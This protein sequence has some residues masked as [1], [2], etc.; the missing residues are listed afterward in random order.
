MDRST[1]LCKFIRKLRIDHDDRQ[2][3]M[4]VK[5]G[6]TPAFLSKVETQKRPMPQEWYY[7]LSR[8]YSLDDETKEELDRL[9][10][11]N[12][13]RKSIDLDMFQEKEVDEI[14]N[15]IYENYLRR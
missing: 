12:N 2:L 8:L 7:E 4:A 11:F 1:D 3:D 15:Y 5:L 14:L 9:M 13:H 10:F 6:V